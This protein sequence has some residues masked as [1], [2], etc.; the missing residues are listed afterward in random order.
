MST[1]EVYL[2]GVCTL[3]HA[4]CELL[5]LANFARCSNCGKSA[6]LISTG[7]LALQRHRW[8][9]NWGIQRG[10]I[11]KDCGVYLWLFV[12]GSGW[13]L[14]GYTIDVATGSGGCRWPW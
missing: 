8:P 11:G 3:R 12:M 9:L 4:S 14:F 7:R 1:C 6:W 5:T 10:I 2:E 13:R